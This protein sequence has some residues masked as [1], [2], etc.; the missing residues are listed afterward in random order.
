MGRR[1]GLLVSKYCDTFQCKLRIIVDVRMEF[2]GRTNGQVE[3]E[4]EHSGFHL[5][6][7]FQPESLFIFCTM[8]G[9]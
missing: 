6:N 2:C 5:C 1:V 7:M 9:L 4:D 8:F 3:I